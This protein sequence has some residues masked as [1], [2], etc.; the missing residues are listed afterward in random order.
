MIL[1]TMAGMLAKCAIAWRA[2]PGPCLRPSATT[3]DVSTRGL[4]N[5]LSAKGATGD[6]ADLVAAARLR[7]RNRHRSTQARQH[8]HDMAGYRADRIRAG[9]PR[10]WRIVPAVLK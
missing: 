3:A 6:I 5:S 10:R 2:S 8:Q 9:S 7:H 1:M 4:P